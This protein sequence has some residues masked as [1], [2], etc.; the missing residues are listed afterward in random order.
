M[1]KPAAENA[2]ISPE[3]KVR[4]IRAS[5]FNKKSSSIMGRGVNKETEETSGSGSVNLEDSMEVAARARPKRATRVQAKY[6][7]SDSDTEE[8]DGTI[9]LSDTESENDDDFSEDED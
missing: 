2:G 7:I 9:E 8:D 3:K 4:K 6:V 5:P 1:L